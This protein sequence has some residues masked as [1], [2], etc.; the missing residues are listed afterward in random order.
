[1][2]F[3]FLTSIGGVDQQQWGLEFLRQGNRFPFSGP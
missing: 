3:S 2:A 1:M